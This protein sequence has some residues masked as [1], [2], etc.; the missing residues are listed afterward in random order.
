MTAV[1]YDTDVI[2]R[3]TLI[4]SSVSLPPNSI[5]SSAQVQAGANLDASKLE[6]RFFPS[7]AQPN[8]AATTETRTL[9]VARRAGTIND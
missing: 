5:T 1:T 7:H 4:A 3:G 6:Q 8:S 2:V 9:F